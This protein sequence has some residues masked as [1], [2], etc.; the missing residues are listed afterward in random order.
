LDQDELALAT[1]VHEQIHWFV[2]GHEAAAEAAIA[3]F[4]QLYPNAPS[5][6]PEGAR[7]KRSTYL[8]L[9]VNYWEYRALGEL[10]GVER[11]R[12]ILAVRRECLYTWIYRTVLDDTD[13]VAA[14]VARHGL[15]L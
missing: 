8:H 9:I 12:R 2:A 15:L 10:L 3:E 5:A 13:T 7:T 6:P 14:V 4:R 1:F 11:A